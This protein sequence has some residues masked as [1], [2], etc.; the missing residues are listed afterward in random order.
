MPVG[1]IRPIWSDATW[2][3]SVNQRLPS[4]P[5]VIPLGSLEAVGMANWLIMPAG[6]IRPIWLTMSSVNQRLPSGPDVI[7]LGK[8]SGV[9]KGD[10]LTVSG[11]IVAGAVTVALLENVVELLPR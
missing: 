5:D 6:V 7:P 11:K 8:A 3:T 10:S 1:V 4:G 2:L 9:G